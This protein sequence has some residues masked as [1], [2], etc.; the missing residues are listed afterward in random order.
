MERLKRVLGCDSKSRCLEQQ[1]LIAKLRDQMH[2]SEIRIEF[3]E[4]TIRE[5]DDELKVQK[6][7]T[8]NMWK[9]IHTRHRLDVPSA[10]GSIRD[11]LQ[12]RE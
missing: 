8:A 12:R 7:A 1:V 4:K 5:R 10:A 3:L 9:F 11:I 6:N 2:L